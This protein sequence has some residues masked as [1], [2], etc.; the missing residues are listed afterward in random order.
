MPK[1]NPNK[2]PKA[3]KIVIPDEKLQDFANSYTIDVSTAYA[4]AKSKPMFFSPVCTPQNWNTVEEHKIGPGDYVDFDD[5]I[6]KELEKAFGKPYNE[7]SVAVGKD[8]P[9]KPKTPEDLCNI[10]NENFKL[11]SDNLHFFFTRYDRYTHR[12]F[13]QQYISGLPQFLL[14]AHAH[15]YGWD[16]S[17][18]AVWTAQ[19]TE[20]LMSWDTIA[21]PNAYNRTLPIAG[22]MHIPSVQSISY[23]EWGFEI[24][25]NGGYS[26][27]A[28][29]RYALD[30]NNIA[31]EMIEREEW[32][33]PLEKRYVLSKP[34]VKWSELSPEEAAEL[35]RA[36][37][38]LPN[39]QKKSDMNVGQRK[40]QLD[41]TE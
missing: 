30:I 33:L 34:L 25:S 35:N 8:N 37:D 26:A 38:S 23:Y 7:I 1:K 13:C 6:E 27:F 32:H 40:V 16:V 22:S 10:I 28:I 29:M 31:H 21:N 3:Q 20:T 9:E 4:H 11:R 5:G 18:N 15:K 36:L 41:L 24:M 39:S 19:K 12:F 2:P 14:M 17:M